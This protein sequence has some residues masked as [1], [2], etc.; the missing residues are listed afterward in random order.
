MTRGRSGIVDGVPRRRVPVDEG[1]FDFGLSPEKRPPDAAAID[2]GEVCACPRLEASDWDAVESDWSDIRFLRGSL[3]AVGGVPV[4]YEG[5][6]EGLLQKAGRLGATVPEDAMVLLG[7][8]K[9]RRP[10]LL[11]VEGIEGGRGDVTAPGG[12]AWTRMRPAPWGQLPK[13]AERVRAEARERYGR[14]PDDFW[15][16]YLTC[17]HCSAAR[18]F[19]TLFVAHYRDGTVP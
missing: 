18:D 15:V 19:E 11:E 10:I 1:G 9:F 13:L 2:E 4:G 17:R 6:K 12:V 14:P 16:W 5:A 7:S 3:T 8:G